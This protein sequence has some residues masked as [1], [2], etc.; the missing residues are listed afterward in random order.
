MSAPRSWKMKIR[1]YSGGGAAQSWRRALWARLVVSGQSQGDG[2]RRFYGDQK[3]LPGSGV[4]V[5]VSWW[6]L[7][8]EFEETPGESSLSFFTCGNLTGNEELLHKVQTIVMKKNQSVIDLVCL[9]VYLLRRVVVVRLSRC[10]SSQCDGK[11]LWFL[12]LI[13]HSTAPDRP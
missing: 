8:A 11:N 7:G 2:W 4:E 12:S 5:T 10:S 3:N 1:F 9:V 13:N 6:S